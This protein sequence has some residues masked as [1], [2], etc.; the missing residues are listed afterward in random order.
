MAR[1]TDWE[2][3]IGRRVTLRDLHILSTVV[4]WGSMAKAASHLAMS[5]SAVSES[6]SHLEAAISVRLLDRT[7][8]GI[9]P[10]IYAETLLKRGHVVFDELQQ[11]IEDIEFLANPT[12]GEVRIACPEFLT[13]WLMPRTI[14]KLSCRFPQVVVRVFQPDTTTLE[15]RELRER[16][17]DI[18]VTRVPK[19]F[20]SDIFDI[21]VLFD[22]PH[23]VVAGA[24]SRWAQRHKIAIAELS[25][26]P[27]I[28]P[29][30]PVL[31]TLLKEMFE[32]EGLKPPSRRVIA[33]SVILRMHLLATG[34]FLSVFPKSV[35]R[36]AAQQWSI[37][38]LPFDLRAKAQPIG[39]LTLKNRT[40]SRVAQVFIEEL[41]AVAKEVPAA[42]STAKD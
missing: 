41:R 10:T 23:F 19:N 33:G 12:V 20:A 11:A 1:T 22:D 28:I 40:L 30:S 6:I 31:E 29:P 16:S 25:N 36:T 32:T 34:R 7:P 17:V 42:A 35:L 3:R 39:I 5:Q 8:Q 24:G 9:E 37:K 14:D 27:W 21:E 15:H 18:V 38:V 13:E 2:N 26:E 4:R